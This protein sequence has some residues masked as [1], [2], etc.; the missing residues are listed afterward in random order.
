M[1]VVGIDHASFP[2]S[3]PEETIAFRGGGIEAPS[4]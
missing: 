1:S 2:T 4:V 3:R